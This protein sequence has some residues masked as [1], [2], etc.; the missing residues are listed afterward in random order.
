ML[1]PTAGQSRTRPRT[2]AKT[3][4]STP[5]RAMRPRGGCWGEATPARR[6]DLGNAALRPGRRRAGS[7]E[8]FP[9]FTARTAVHPPLIEPSS[10]PFPAN[11]DQANLR[12]PEGSIYRCFLPDLTGFIGSCRAGPDLPC[13]LARVVPQGEDRGQGFNPAVADCGYRAPLAPRLARPPK[14]TTR[15]VCP[16]Q[17]SRGR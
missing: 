15:G 7:S 11:S 1:P 14:H 13:R 8:A 17:S 6:G 12:H 2:G 10:L 9:L 16:C 4:A 3:A 5:R